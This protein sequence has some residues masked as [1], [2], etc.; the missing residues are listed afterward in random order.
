MATLGL[1]NSIAPALAWL[2]TGKRAMPEAPDTEGR[3][4][5]VFVFMTS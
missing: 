5:D 4:R 2:A 1:L 3:G